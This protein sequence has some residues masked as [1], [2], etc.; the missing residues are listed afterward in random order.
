MSDKTYWA[1]ADGLREFARQDLFRL[2]KSIEG[3]KDLFID[4]DLFPLIDL[5][6]NAAEIR[7]YSVEN[8]HKLDA[9]L[10]SK[11]KNKRVFLLRPN[12]VRFLTIAK[13]IRQLDIRNAN[14]VCVPRKFYAF[15]H[16]LEQE[17]LYG[18]CK[19]H[20]LPSFDMVP[21]D[22]D[23]F[24]MVNSHL[25]LNV[26]LDQSTDWLSTLASSLTD[27]QSLFGRFS[28]TISFGKLAGQVARQLEREQK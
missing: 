18:R 6:S 7:A 23:V 24:S 16:L 5:T 4:A 13:Q 9:N 15:E 12:M 26:Y 1:I 2:L 21:L 11:S 22:Y 25:F 14:L 20:E 27:F 8:L 19:L 17:G 3:T 28:N 10:N